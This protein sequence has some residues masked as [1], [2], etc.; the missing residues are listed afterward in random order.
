M[1]EYGESE[2]YYNDQ[3]V[4]ESTVMDVHLGILND[5]GKNS[6]LDEPTA[7]AACT[8]NRCYQV[9]ELADSDFDDTTL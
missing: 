1:N 2:R 5:G 6:F 9:Y 4:D 3:F 7:L 8:R